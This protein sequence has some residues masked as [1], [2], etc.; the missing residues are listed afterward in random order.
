M[1]SEMLS[2]LYVDDERIICESVKDYFEDL[3]LHVFDD[4]TKALESLRRRPFDIVVVDYRMPKLS[5]LDLLIEAKKS[6]S[7]CYGILLTAYADTELLEQFINRNLI[8]KVLEKPVDLEYLRTVLM[9]AGEECEAQRLREEALEG[10]DFFRT[11]ISGRREPKLP[12]RILGAAGG[13]RKVFLTAQRFAESD[14]NILITG[15]T[16]TGKEV[17][18]RLIHSM[19]PRARRAFVKINCG[20]IPESLIESELFGFSKGAF[21]GAS[22]DKPGRIELANGGTLFLDEVAELKPEL[23]TRLLAVV[24]D[25]VVERLGGTEETPVDFRLIA[26]TNRNLEEAMASGQFREDLYFRLSTL[27]LHVAALREYRDDI[28][29]FVDELIATGSEE[30]NRR[31]PTVTE[32]ALAHL[33]NYPWPGNIRELENVISRVL[34]LLEKG[35]SQVELSDV[36]FLRPSGTING[37]RIQSAIAPFVDLLVEGSHSIDE[38]EHYVLEA[39]LKRYDGDVMETVR[40]TGVPKDRF[41]RL[42]KS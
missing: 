1:N 24:Q 29:E 28:D 16:G 25:K 19:S 38:L 12:R 34:I 20:S 3:D 14:E 4:P 18:A 35:K 40:A 22:H 8:R 9:E 33:R 32:A 23:Q 17:V 7:Y 26:A 21:S 42:K 31:P 30:M 6:N 37:S 39:T 27:P 41:Y 11:L 36:S 5:G 10:Q 15:E 13:L 2:I